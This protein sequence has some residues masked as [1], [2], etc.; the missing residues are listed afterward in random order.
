MAGSEQGWRAWGNL[1]HSVRTGENAF[2][3]VFGM[4]SFQ[5]T[6]LEPERAKVFDDYMADLT[7]RSVA[8]IVSAHDFSGY[9]RI[10]DVGGGNGALMSSVLA[11]VPDAEGFILDTPTG[12]EGARR[13][14]EQ[15]GVSARCRIVA[16]DFFEAV[17]EAADAYILKSIL[18]DWDDDRAIA[19]LGNCH[20]EMGSGQQAPRRNACFRRESNAPT[21]TARS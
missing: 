19:I 16:G 8:A 5:Y 7:R 1:L 3:H 18:H 17:P 12:V 21:P 11:A 14:L 2:E 13:R 15:A 4:G 6:A 9:R 10:V 20:R